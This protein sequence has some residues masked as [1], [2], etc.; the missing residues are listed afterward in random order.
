MSK[1]IETLQTAMT[2][3]LAV[4]PTVHGFPYFVEVLRQDGAVVMQHTRESSGDLR[5][6][7]AQ[8]ASG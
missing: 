3:A 8:V 4:R 1:A 5:V 7:L 2:R 6:L